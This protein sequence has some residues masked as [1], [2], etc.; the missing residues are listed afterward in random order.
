MCA[1]PVLTYEQWFRVAL[2]PLQ[3]RALGEPRRGRRAS[4]TG[5]S[6]AGTQT[7]CRIFRRRRHEAFPHAVRSRELVLYRRSY[8]PASADPVVG[9]ASMV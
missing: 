4:R 8:V 9:C 5:P 7:K 3:A 2:H 6:G 1:S